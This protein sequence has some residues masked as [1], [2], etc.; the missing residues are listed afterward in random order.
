[1]DVETIIEKGRKR[2]TAEIGAILKR[3]KAFNSGMK[4]R[5]RVREGGVSG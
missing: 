2:T 5:G 3:N 1:M 4:V